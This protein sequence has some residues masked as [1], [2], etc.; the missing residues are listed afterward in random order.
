VNYLLGSRYDRVIQLGIGESLVLRKDSI[1][2][3][4]VVG[5]SLVESETF[6]PGA[7]DYSLNKTVLCD[8]PGFGDTRSTASTVSAVAMSQAMVLTSQGITKILLTLDAPTIMTSRGNSLATYLISLKKMFGEISDEALSSV[9]IVLTKFPTGIS[10]QEFVDHYIIPKLQELKNRQDSL[11]ED[12]KTVL[13][14]CEYLAA[15]VSIFVFVDPCDHGESANYL[16]D[17]IDSSAPTFFGKLNLIAC[18]DK[19]REFMSEVTQ[20]VS[21]VNAGIEYEAG[22]KERVDLQLLQV[23]DLSYAARQKRLSLNKRHDQLNEKT[24][25]IDDLKLICQ[26]RVNSLSECIENESAHYARCHEELTQSEIELNRISNL[27]QA[28]SVSTQRFDV[29]P[30]Q[31]ANLAAAAMMAGFMRKFLKAPSNNMT[32]VLDKT[33]AFVFESPG[34]ICAVHL[35]GGALPLAGIVNQNHLSY[36][37]PYSIIRGTQAVVEVFI[38][39]CDTAENQKAIQQLKE[40]IPLLQQACA[41]SQEIILSIQQKYDEEQAGLIKIDT[42]LMKIEGDKAQ[43]SELLAQLNSEDEK[44]SEDIKKIEVTIEEDFQQCRGFR[45]A[46]AS[47]FPTL[48]NISDLLS[49]TGQAELPLYSMQQA[50]FC[51]HTAIASFFADPVI[52][53]KTHPTNVVTSSV[54]FTQ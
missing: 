49:L 19:A 5:Q 50:Q 18:D 31:D 6:I 15:H 17:R 32:S 27:T 38:R 35:N 30:I 25:K 40:K 16:L 54:E 44:Q 26:H 51:A 20:I 46:C 12:E 37:H 8:L 23:T 3:R 21:C 11:T 43:C 24:K 4:S 39:E 1:P 41:Q 14:V 10:N 34:P 33:H 48:K 9:L 52:P 47:L 2:E 29:G 42:E 36:A 28:V 45:R 22:L 7:Y 53:Q 13:E